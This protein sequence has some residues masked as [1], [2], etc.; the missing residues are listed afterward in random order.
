MMIQE[1]EDLTGFYPT[2][3]H[4]AA[5]EAAYSE[6][7]GSKQEFCKAFKANKDG[8]AEAIARKVNLSRLPAEQAI[9]EAE[10]KAA[11]EVSSLKAEM[12]RL[13]AALEREEEWR[14]YEDKDNVS[15]ADYVA[16]AESVKTG[17]ARYLTDDEALE[18]VSREFGFSVRRVEILHEVDVEEINRHNQIR[19]TG[20]VLDRRPI[21]GASDDA[22]VRF[23]VA[24][25]M[26]E[27]WNGE[28]QLFAG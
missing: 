20:K 15:Q 19:R 4:Y 26:Y 11:Q 2:L 12:E 13:R 6:F 23:N 1:F 17:A 10:A 9:A 27:G 25:R 24:G 7:H 3:E 22:Y 5:I 14:P 28:L 16:L 8:M 21:Y 18:Y